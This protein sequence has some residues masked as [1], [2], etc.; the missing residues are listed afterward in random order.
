MRLPAQLPAGGTV[1]FH[2]RAE[3]MRIALIEERTTG[4]AAR[5]YGKTEHG[6]IQGD[7]FHLGKMTAALTGGA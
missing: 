5:P 3:R 1:S 2:Y 6:R 7:P 4:Q